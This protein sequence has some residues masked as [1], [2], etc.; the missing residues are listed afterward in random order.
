MKGIIA[1]DIDGTIANKDH[2]IPKDVELFL[3][4]LAKEG[5]IL[6]FLT[7]RTFSF[8]IMSI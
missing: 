7:G 6:A 5:W 1:L 8:T 4:K 3:H 2:L